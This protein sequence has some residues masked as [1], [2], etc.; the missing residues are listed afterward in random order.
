M[1]EGCSSKKQEVLNG[2]PIARCGILP[3]ELYQ[4]DPKMLE[5]LSPAFGFLL[6]LDD[7]TALL[8][9]LNTLSTGHRET[10]LELN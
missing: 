9:T 2:N 8:K 10:K 4:G 5:T 6:K 1:V 7:E 3:Y